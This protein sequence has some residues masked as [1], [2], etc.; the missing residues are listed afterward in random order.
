MQLSHLALA[1]AV[2]ALVAAVPAKRDTIASG[3]IFAPPSDGP[4]VQSVNGNGMNNGTLKNGPTVTGKAFDRIIQ[5]W[6]ENTDAAT[7]FSTPA[8]MDLAKQGIS[9][10]SSYGVT[11]P[12]EPNYLAAVTGDFFGLADDS[13]NHVPTNITS[14]F[15]LLDEKAISWTCYQEN[16]PTDGYTG[17]N[18][19]QKAYIN[20]SATWTY[21]VRKHNPCAMLDGVSGN[22]TRRERNRNFNDL[23]ADVNGNAVPQWTFITP[24]MVN[25]GHDT[26]PAFLSNWTDFFLV[27]LLNNTN[28]NTNRTLIV[29]TFDEDEDYTV[30]NRIATILLGGAVPKELVGTSDPTYYTHYSLLSTVELNWGLK[31]L[32]RGDVNKTMAN[33][34]SFVAEKTGYQ[35][36]NVSEA[37][38]PQTNLTGV[39]PGPLSAT[40]YTNF[41]A[42]PN[43]NVTGP[44]GQGV[45]ILPGMNMS[46]ILTANT[47]T[48]N[49]TATGAKRPYGTDPYAPAS[50][51]TTAATSSPSGAAAPSLRVAGAG[52]G[53][54]AAAGLAVVGAAMFTL[55]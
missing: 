28:F 46:Q 4:T 27:P 36:M 21:Y 16:L 49:L 17:F 51:S 10:T 15:D 55:L 25:D 29:L 11:H 12:S 13:F 18:Y 7:A 23:A 40:Y 26:S 45:L 38:R 34:L 50:T 31:H 14:V 22:A 47:P 1:A 3:L 41:Y 42:P 20:G 2:P 43:A 53:S 39:A 52:L 54:L 35:N 5:I 37:D 33:V 9:L 32:G 30:N 8:F 6:L 44:G 24:N 48:V 19:T